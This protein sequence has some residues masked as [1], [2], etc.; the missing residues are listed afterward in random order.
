MSTHGISQC[1]TFGFGLRVSHLLLFTGF[2]LLENLLECV[3]PDF[4]FC[5]EVPDGGKT[6]VL[7]DTHVHRLPQ[8]FTAL[9]SCLM[10]P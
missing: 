8:A 4:A 5:F 9:L 7:L 6:C 3:E 1:L 2:I 10:N